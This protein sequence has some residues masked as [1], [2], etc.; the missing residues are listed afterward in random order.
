M[1]DPK[2]IVVEFLSLLGEGN[3]DDAFELVDDDL[4]HKVA[5]FG[6][7][8]SKASYRETL[9]DFYSRFTDDG[10]SY[11]M[12]EP[13]AEGDRVAV[14]MVG[15]GTGRSGKPYCNYYANFYKVADEKI[16]EVYEFVDLI[17]I[18]EV[19]EVDPQEFSEQA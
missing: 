5:G 15:R 16:V 19:L 11:E 12:D 17:H 8:T 18:Q 7:Y 2:S 14:T 13:I 3:A 4:R 10:V 1:K 9:E 6:E